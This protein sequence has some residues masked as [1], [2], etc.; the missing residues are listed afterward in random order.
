MLHRHDE[1][2]LGLEFACEKTHVEFVMLVFDTLV[3]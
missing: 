3:E 1:S 2:F